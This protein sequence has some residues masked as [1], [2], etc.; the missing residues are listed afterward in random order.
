MSKIDLKA[1]LDA[2]F[3]EQYCESGYGAIHP[4]SRDI[5]SFF[6]GRLGNRIPTGSC[7]YKPF[8]KECDCVQ[9][10]WVDSL[11]E[12]RDDLYELVLQ[13]DRV[14]ENTEDNA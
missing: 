9:E 10:Y 2:A 4:R 8:K 11:K 3:S 1:F 14:I 12:L 6:A 13:I 5:K 7:L